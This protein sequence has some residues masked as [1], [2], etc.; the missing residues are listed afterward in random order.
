MVAPIFGPAYRC[1]SVITQ[2][3]ED[4]VRG[5]RRWPPFSDQPLNLSAAVTAPKPSHVGAAP[6]PSCPPKRAAPCWWPRPFRRVFR[7]RPR[8]LLRPGA[9]PAGAT[10][11]GSGSW[12]FAG[13][14]RPGIRWRGSG[15]WRGSRRRPAGPCRAPAAAGSR[16]GLHP[17]RRAWFGSRGGRHA[18]PSAWR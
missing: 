7:G 9:A 17:R 8:Y 1:H 2:D 11:L 14:K 6:G 10:G 5:S 18:A 4:V 13:A 12:Q 16:T 15:R 3:H